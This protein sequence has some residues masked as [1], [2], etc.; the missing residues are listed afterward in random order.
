MKRTQARENEHWGFNYAR[1]LVQ[2]NY[3]EKSTLASVYR[4]FLLVLH[5]RNSFCQ[6]FFLAVIHIS[7]AWKWLN[8]PPLISKE[9]QTVD[10][11][12]II[13]CGSS[14]T[15]ASS[16]AKHF[17]GAPPRKKI[18]SFNQKCVNSSWFN[19]KSFCNA[20]SGFRLTLFNKIKR[21]PKQNH[22]EEATK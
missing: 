13:F 3:K 7:K 18:F 21:A 17:G 6:V 22:F 12:F 15:T 2:I 9:H 10:S 8:L 11:N 19:V 16:S 14:I 5:P 20:L 1:N 4:C